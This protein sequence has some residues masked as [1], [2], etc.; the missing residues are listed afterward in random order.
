MSD[1]EEPPTKMSKYEEYLEEPEEALD[2]GQEEWLS[3]GVL[4]DEDYHGTMA[5]QD[6]SEQHLDDSNATQPEEHEVLEEST[7][8][9]EEMETVEQPAEEKNDD[10][11][12]E[13]TLNNLDSKNQMNEELETFLVKKAEVKE[14]ESNMKE[15]ES[16][17]NAPE[18][19]DGNDT[20][21]LLRLLEDDQQSKKK[22]LKLVKSE[23]ADNGSSDDDD[24]E[25]IYERS[26]VKTLKL[27]KNALIKRI[28]SKAVPENMS[29][30]DDDSASSDEGVTMKRMFGVK[31]PKVRDHGPKK[32]VKHV[33][34]VNSNGHKSDKSQHQAQRVLKP[35]K[36]KFE[37]RPYKL[38][39][40]KPPAP[41][42]PLDKGGAK[43][44]KSEDKPEE[45][46]EIIDGEEFL[47]EDEFE[48][49]EEE[50][51]ESEGETSKRQRIM[52]PEIMDEEVPSDDD[53]HSEDGSL[54]D[55]LPSSDSEDFDDWFTLD[56]RAERASDY[57][58][59]LG[60]CARS[61]LQ[62]ERRRASS[63]V[64]TLRQSLSA[65]TDSAR[66]QAEHLRAAAMA[67]AEL[68]DTLRAA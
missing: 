39:D 30:T 55:E 26:K 56:V 46:D 42:K 16:S 29:D 25:F 48:L 11:N 2:E 18:E 32:V 6:K 35:L 9:T 67:L 65:L 68:D 21:D 4:T 24:D 61:L 12:I 1:V 8:T 59:L 17:Q 10:Q 49:D 28:P 43:P 66:R 62:A 13:D 20:D 45:A 23:Q 58:P 57:L 40:I 31:G 14:T 63:R 60:N 41:F 33:V 37:A 36:A 51:V 44:V 53:S 3:E 15:D 64:T 54:Y 22:T 34:Q 38:V 50:F 27:A 7:I 47:E 52:R 5:E 19:D